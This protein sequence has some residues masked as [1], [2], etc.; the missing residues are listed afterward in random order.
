MESLLKWVTEGHLIEVE[1]LLQK[2]PQLVFST[3]TVT[4]LSNRT[5][6]NITVFQ[7]AVWALD[8]EM[9]D[10]IL[11]YL[12][13]PSACTQLQL[14]EA[15]PENYSQYGANYDI[16]PYNQNLDK[17]SLIANL[18]INV[19]MIGKTSAAHSGNFQHGWYMQCAK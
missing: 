6:K 1:K 5:F 17:Y 3:G 19:R 8:I 4:D 15:C 10:V 12:D 2:N 14:L 11:N 7:Y 13:K 18:M 16:T 9:W